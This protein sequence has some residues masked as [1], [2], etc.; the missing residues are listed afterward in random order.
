MLQVFNTSKKFC[1]EGF[2][3]DNTKLK[4]VKGCSFPGFHLE[5]C[6]SEI[7]NA[8]YATRYKLCD[9]TTRPLLTF[10]CHLRRC[11]KGYHEKNPPLYLKSKV[12][13]SK[14]VRECKPG[15][16]L[17]IDCRKSKEGAREAL[18]KEKCT[19]DGRI[20]R[21]KCKIKRC[22]HGYYHNKDKN[23]CEKWECTP[24]EELK[25]S[26]PSV[27]RNSNLTFK[28]T[29]CSKEGKLPNFDQVACEKLS[30][31][32]GYILRD[33]RCV[34]HN[35][36]YVNN[37]KRLKLG[38]LISHATVHSHFKHKGK[39]VIV[40]TVYNKMIKDVIPRMV[41]KYGV[42]GLIDR[43]N[44]IVLMDK[45]DAV[46]CRGTSDC[47][48][49]LRQK[50]FDIA[51][52]RDKIF[53]V[54]SKSGNI[55]EVGGKYLI[56]SHFPGYWEHEFSH[57]MGNN[58]GSEGS[59][60]PGPM[61]NYNSNRMFNLTGRIVTPLQE[62][63]TSKNHVNRKDFGHY[64][65][66]E[67]KTNQWKVKPTTLLDFAEFNLEKDKS[68][69]IDVL[70]NDFDVNNQD[71]RIELKSR[72]SRLG[73]KLVI[74]EDE[75]GAP[76]IE[77]TPT[78]WWADTDSF[79]YT[80]VD[81]DNNKADAIV[82]VHSLGRFFRGAKYRL[83]ADIKH[84]SNSSRTWASIGTNLTDV[85]QREANREFN[86]ELHEAKG[87][88]GKHL[89]IRDGRALHVDASGKG[90]D[91]API[92]L[93]DINH[94]HS[95]QRWIFEYEKG[96]D[97]NPG[98]Y[99]IKNEFSDTYLTFIKEGSSYKIKAKRNLNRN[100]YQKWGIFSNRYFNKYW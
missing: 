11:K 91:E 1:E 70:K 16:Q 82:V 85:W 57:L 18:I 83:S 96:H 4:C 71:L 78:H 61:T 59:I 56:T 10:E 22:R 100:M 14:C 26:C 77:Y 27:V 15:K 17:R 48:N 58:H 32:N 34:N 80:A 62:F 38:V 86:W 81:P 44:I 25:E 31:K 55:G 5:N 99:K 66:D 13:T 33:D 51:G 93:R 64:S 46:N 6:T 49:K 50:F 75:T 95:K 42:H 2:F 9:Y 28:K 73:A 52:W 23:R 60:E 47:K 45:K 76:Y 84:T 92:A 8:S 7:K 98:L 3:L 24:G 12:F 40:E 41:H 68:I 88:P 39:D 35:Q 63:I 20:P 29:R 21:N 87:H 30:C 36:D 79:T 89:I 37:M 72:E 65:G 67:Y 53:L 94:D 74:N 69:K 97:N 90:V 54:H 19:F 43:K